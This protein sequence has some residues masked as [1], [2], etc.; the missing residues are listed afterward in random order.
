MKLMKQIG[1]DIEK[2][3]KNNFVDDD[4]PCVEV[5]R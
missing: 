3:L 5:W 4:N 2:D 1:I